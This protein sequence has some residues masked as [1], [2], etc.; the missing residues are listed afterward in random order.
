MHVVHLSDARGCLPLIEQC[1]RTDSIGG[2]L[3]VETCPHYLMLDDTL[4]EDGDTRV[5]CFPPIRDAR[6]RELLWKG[7]N[8]GLVDMIASDHSPCEPSMRLMESGDFQASWGGLSGLQYQLQA[9][10]KDAFARG[11]TPLQMAQWWSTNPAQLAGLSSQKGRIAPGFQADLCWWDPEFVGA[12]N[13]YSEEHHRWKG[14]TRFAED[15]TMRGRVLGTWVRGKLVYDGLGDDHKEPI[16]KLLE[17][18]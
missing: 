10:W 2:R 13:S 17:C 4:I 14:T 6:N 8:D 5:K 12:P 16:G 9:T 15:P 3:T 7:L 18:Q 1:K 11:C